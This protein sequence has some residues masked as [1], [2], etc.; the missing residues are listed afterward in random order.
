[1]TDYTRAVLNA[2]GIKFLA[3]QAQMNAQRLREDLSS[4]LALQN[5]PNNTLVRIFGADIV[6]QHPNLVSVLINIYCEAYEGLYDLLQAPRARMTYLDF[7]KIATK[8]FDNALAVQSA[9][10]EEGANPDALQSGADALR[11]IFNRTMIKTWNHC[12]QNQPSS[13]PRL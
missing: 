3:E 1:M 9:A 4:L 11:P 12:A 10:L 5:D 13:G 8:A 2:S 7:R 6:Q